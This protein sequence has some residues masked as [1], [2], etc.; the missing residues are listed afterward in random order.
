MF[1]RWSYALAVCVLSQWCMAGTFHID[2]RGEALYQQ[3]VPY[4]QQANSKLEA[5][6]A[7]T[8]TASTEEKEHAMALAEEA[9]AL[10]KPA[11]ALLEQAVT[12][13]HPVAQYRLGLIYIM[14]YP[15]EVVTEKACPLFEQ[16]LAH[17]FAPPA[18]EM[19]SWCI[20]YTD[21]PEYQAALQAIE[22]R[23]PMYEK[24]FPQPTVKFECRREEALGL[25]MQWGDS[26]DYQAEIYRLQGDSNRARRSE[27]YQKA[28]DINDCYRV[29]N[30]WGIANNRLS[31]MPRRS[32]FAPLRTSSIPT[33]AQQ[34]THHAY[35]PR[36]SPV[37]HHLPDPGNPPPVCGI[38]LSTEPPEHW[39]FYRNK[40]TPDSLKLPPRRPTGT[41]PGH[42]FPAPR[43]FR[44]AFART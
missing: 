6:P 34:N 36:N 28:L 33:G 26:R 41:M 31:I 9:G 35:P 13:D 11:I 3:A 22:T 14:V 44:R 17:G 2:P 18:L 19:S 1:S 7:D 21:T 25:A 39:F 30:A 29:K 27:Y 16:S 8:P 40:L 4:L 12:F 37:V 38:T 42:P 24:Y 15:S 43:R 5:I 32:I 10:L 23:M 20:P